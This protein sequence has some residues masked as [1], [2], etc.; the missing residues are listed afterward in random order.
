MAKGLAPNEALKKAY[1]ILDYTIT[2]QAGIL[3]YMDVFLYLGCL[4][5][6]CIPFILMA[7]KS[8][9]GPPAAAAH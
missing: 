1:A 9:G 7:R 3:S 2:T 5:L 4:F 6:V 8:K